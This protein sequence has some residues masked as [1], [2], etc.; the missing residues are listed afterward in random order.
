MTSPQPGANAKSKPGVK[1]HYPRRRDL[2]VLRVE[3]RG[4]RA[5]RGA[6]GEDGR[7]GGP[8]QFDPA[9]LRRTVRNIAER[10]RV[11]RFDT[12]RPPRRRNPAKGAGSWFEEGDQH[13]APGRGDGGVGRRPPFGCGLEC[14]RA[15]AALDRIEGVVDG[16][17]G[18]R[19]HTRFVEWVVGGSEAGGDGGLAG[20]LVPGAD[21]I[22]PDR[23][24]GV[25]RSR[26][27]R[28]CRRRDQADQKCSHTHV[29]LLSARALSAGASETAYTPGLFRS[30]SGRRSISPRGTG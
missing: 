19:V 21:R 11:V 26:D 17:V 10:L 30:V 29:S 7:G 18:D 5:V 12:R 23:R 15:R 24:M 3:Q 4:V 25:R 6:E 13:I 14:V 1:R 9:R 20:I 27:C 16:Q 28:R 22:R 2:W 8:P